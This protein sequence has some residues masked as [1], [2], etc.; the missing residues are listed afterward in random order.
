MH[1]ELKGKVKLWPLDK[2][3]TPRNGVF[4]V[5]V[6]YWWSV[7]DESLMFYRPKGMRGFGSAQCNAKRELAERLNAD[8]YPEAEVRQIPV[9]YIPVE[10]GE[11]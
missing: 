2:A 3:T 10:R 8:L 1:A 6:N 11:F 5:Y 7:K 9:V 4:Q